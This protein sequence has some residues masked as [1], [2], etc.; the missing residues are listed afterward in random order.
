[1]KRISKKQGLNLRSSRGFTIV[2]I[3]VVIAI[4][5]ILAAIVFV[6]LNPAKRFQDANNAQRLANVNAILN[7]IGQNIVD[8]KGKF[9]KDTSCDTEVAKIA[10]SAKAIGT[11]TVNLQLCL[12]DYLAKLPFDPKGGTAADT[13]YEIKT[14]SS[15]GYTISAPDAEGGAVIEVTR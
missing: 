8:N 4:I 9:T 1:M 14:S 3:L 7:A 10:S 5:A 13:G 11:D 2:E 6:S 12:T 15:G